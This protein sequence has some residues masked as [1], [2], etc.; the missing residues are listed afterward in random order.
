MRKGSLLAVAAAILLAGAVWGWNAIRQ[1]REFRRLIAA[2][3]AALARDQ[4]FEA[5][6]DF[7]GALAL[8][9]DSMVAHLKRGDSY[10]RRGELGAAL[11]DL[12]DAAALDERSLAGVDI[13]PADGASVLH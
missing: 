7:S 5:I 8:K 11:R 2:G 3:D 9:Q 12:R 6:E 13:R 10:R 1:E 4:T